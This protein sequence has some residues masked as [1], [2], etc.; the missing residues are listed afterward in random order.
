MTKSA[1]RELARTTVQ[2]IKDRLHGSPFDEVTTRMA[3]IEIESLLS[4]RLVKIPRVADLGEVIAQVYCNERNC[5]K[6]MDAD[7]VL[8]I[9]YAIVNFLKEEDK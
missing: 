2:F 6:T 4:S 8:D 7:L 1:V 3:E 9:C 5:K